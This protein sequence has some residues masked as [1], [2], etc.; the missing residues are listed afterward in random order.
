MDII[1]E[2]EKK[3]LVNID[4]GRGPQGI[5]GIDGENGENIELQN[6]GT[7][8]QWRVVGDIAWTN[9]IAVADLQGADGTDGVDGTDGTDGREIELQKTATHIQWRYVGD[10][11]VDL[12]SIAEITGPAGT[13]DHGLLIGLGD[14]DHTQYMLLSGRVGGQTL[15]G[16]LNMTDRLSFGTASGTGRINLPDGGTTASDGIQFGI[17][18]SNLYRS[19]ANKLATNGSFEVIG[20][21]SFANYAS[22]LSNTGIILQPSTLTGSSATSALSISQIWNT[23]GNPILI[24]GIVTP[25]AFGGASALIRLGTTVNTAI[26]NVS[27][28]G[29]VICGS[30]IAF[31]VNNLTSVSSGIIRLSDSGALNFNRLNFGFENSSNPALKRV[32][33]TLQVRLSNDSDFSFIEDLYRRVGSGSPEGVVAAPVGARYSRTDGGAGT[34]FYVKESG[35]GN[36]GW[37]AK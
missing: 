16:N 7:F 6:S 27:M 13:T 23:T 22:A 34:S 8:I 25:T 19:G 12:I 10:T 29:N 28:T 24:Q 30:N 21:I 37:V 32:G 4:G 18:N 9:L 5:Q 11:W 31:G 35:T 15:S 36:T 14:D 26:F 2:V 20:S 17:G 1:V 3:V 33:A